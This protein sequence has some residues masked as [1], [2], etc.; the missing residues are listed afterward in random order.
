MLAYHK[1]STVLRNAELDHCRQ[2]HALGWYLWHLSAFV[3]KRP[4][5][6]IPVVPVQQDQTG[7]GVCHNTAERLALGATRPE[8]HTKALPDGIYRAPACRHGPA[9]LRARR[10]LNKDY[11]KMAENKQRQIPSSK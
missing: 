7:D 3:C 9:S 6:I 10:N 1:A 5:R 8:R 4:L 2:R 11:L